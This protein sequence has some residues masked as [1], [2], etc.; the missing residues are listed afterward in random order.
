[1]PDLIDVEL[2]DFYGT[3]ILPVVNRQSVFIDFDWA[4]TNSA[5]EG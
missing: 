1:M 2:G 4:A 5:H 3:G